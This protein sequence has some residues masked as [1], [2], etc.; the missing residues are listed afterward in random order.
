MKIKTFLLWVLVLSVSFMLPGFAAAVISTWILFTVIRQATP[1]RD[2]GALTGLLSA[3]LLMRLV[4]FI[5]LQ[6]LVFSKGMT[7]IF[8]DARDN[9]VQGTIFADYFR[10]EFDIGKVLK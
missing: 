7:D 2:R 10:G 9:I 3:A 8:G 5:I 6:Y 1:E 4:L